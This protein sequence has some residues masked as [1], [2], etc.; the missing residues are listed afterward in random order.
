[1]KFLLD[2]HEDESQLSRCRIAA[3]SEQSVRRQRTA[4]WLRRLS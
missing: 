4:R 1:V 3:C 2:A